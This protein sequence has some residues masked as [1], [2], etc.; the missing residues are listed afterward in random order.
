MGIN[1]EQLFLPCFNETLPSRL[2]V[3][4][5]LSLGITLQLYWDFRGP[6]FNAET[7]LPKMHSF[8]GLLQMPLLSFSIYIVFIPFHLLV[9]VLEIFRFVVSFRALKFNSG[10]RVFPPFSFANPQVADRSSK[11]RCDP[12]CNRGFHIYFESTRSSPCNNFLFFF[13]EAQTARHLRAVW[14]ASCLTRAQFTICRHT[15]KK[16][17]KSLRITWR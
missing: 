11:V 16:V 14:R 7:R 12:R 17:L 2:V 13:Q 9:W 5:L 4:V 15:R 8:Y 10:S 6:V 3:T 1:W